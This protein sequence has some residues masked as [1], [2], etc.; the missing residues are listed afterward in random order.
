MLRRELKTP[1]QR[2]QPAYP[3]L[4]GSRDGRRGTHPAPALLPR[5][6]TRHQ[7]LLGEPFPQK[8]HFSHE[9]L[10]ERL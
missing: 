2:P 3:Q 10:V 7:L 1:R 4:G 5:W 8:H 6:E 9:A